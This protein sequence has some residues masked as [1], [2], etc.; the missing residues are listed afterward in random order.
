M[1][2]IIICNI[3][4]VLAAASF[5]QQTNNEAK[6]SSI[7]K[8]YLQTGAGITTGDGTAVDFGMQAVL[9]NEWTIGISY[10]SIEMKPKNLPGNYER[11]VVIALFFPFY[12]EWP[13]NEMDIISVT[14]G[15]YFETGRKTWFTAEGGL[16]FVNGQKIE[17][18]SQPVVTEL[19]YISSNYSYKKED[20]TGVGA[21]LKADFNWAVLPFA[22]VGAGFFA[23]INSVQSA[24]GF[25]VKFICGWLNTKRKH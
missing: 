11:G 4:L 8:F 13:Y 12:D 21:M 5:C 6:K 14:L 23:N 15:K 9:K 1:K 7:K 24:L 25:E 2:K 3:L 16:S 19:F 10:K 20:K 22:G 18:T 17:F